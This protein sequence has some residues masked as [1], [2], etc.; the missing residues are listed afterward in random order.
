MGGRGGGGMSSGFHSSS[1][2]SGSGMRSSGWGGRSFSA[3]TQSYYRS[4]SAPAPQRFS[5]PSQY[6]SS[7]RSSYAS[8]SRTA[9]STSR[10]YAPESTARSTSYAPSWYS[11]SSRSALDSRASLNAPSARY[12]DTG[13]VQPTSSAARDSF[14]LGGLGGARTYSV[15]SSGVAG[16]ASVRTQALRATQRGEG[17]LSAQHESTRSTLSAS[18]W[19]D[20]SRGAGVT[21]RA[22]AATAQRAGSETRGGVARASGAAS[23]RNDSLS[24]ARGATS[25]SR[26]NVPAQMM[27]TS[28]LTSSSAGLRNTATRTEQGRAAQRDA[29]SR[30]TRLNDSNP[31]AAHDVL[32]TSETITSATNVA[33]RT[34]LG[35]ATSVVHG[36]HNTTWWCHSHSGSGCHPGAC[37]GANWWWGCSSWWWP[38][39]GPVWGWAWGFW[40]WGSPY[41]YD[42]YAYYYA[43]PPVYYSTAV[44]PEQQEPT[45]E[46]VA[47]A[48]PPAQPEGA[49]QDNTAHGISEL[50][51][52][53]DQAFH[54]RR[55][56]D[57]VFAYAKAVELAPKDGVLRL[58]FS[59]ALFAAGA[60]HDAAAALRRAL[61]LD[62]KLA[63]S[64]ID[65]HALYADAS[66]LD[67]QIAALEDYV[68][69]H[70][71]D[72]DARL[73]LAAN[74]L[75]A[76]RAQACV[77]L[78]K[79]GFGTKVRESNAG[80]LILA[81]AEEV[82]GASAPK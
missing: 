11:A 69:T 61:E 21:S 63:A 10:R 3:P 24:L 39:W 18:P 62:P 35:A 57:A 47:A 9:P 51:A 22:T 26:S 58:I 66:E 46:A 48:Q 15:A 41:Y 73:L 55:Y 8:P 52:I 14:G 74:Q 40:W 80:K 2:S 70:F 53:G 28:S 49:A 20:A 19:G 6:S 38:W 45:H 17:S 43:P 30:L 79:T 7:S 60:Y 44:Y 71:S 75:F 81:R 36:A 78:L 31:K 5:A 67:H 37:C 76:G 29:V 1:F 77:D 68:Q 13:R 82:A 72:D 4:Y 32:R 23:S 50:L 34:G 65:K 42:P 64:S 54:E 16:P 27:P 59:D 56:S 25:Y 12:A 33:V